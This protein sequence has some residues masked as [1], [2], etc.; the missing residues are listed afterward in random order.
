M[1]K[2][3]LFVAS[4]LTPIAKVGGLGDVIGSLPK[5]LEK[6]GLEI[7]IVIGKYGNIDE[8]KYPLKKLFD[9]Q[10]PWAESDEKVGI[11]S[12]RMPKSNVE[13]LL[14]DHELINTGGVYDS[15]TAFATTDHELKRFLLV[16]RSALASI[17]KLGWKPDAIHIHDWHTSFVP[18][19]LKSVYKADQFLKDIPVLLTIHNLANQGIVLGEIL[20][21]AGL[22]PED[23]P[24]LESDIQD[25]DINFFRQG[26][27]NATLLNTVSPTYAKEILT[28]KFGEGL[29]EILR[30][31]K[32]DLFGILN[33]IDAD[34][35]NSETD[36]DIYYNYSGKTFLKKY[37]NKLALQKELGLSIASKEKIPLLGIVSRLTDQKGG[38]LVDEIIDRLVELNCQLV[39]LGQGDPIHENYYKKAAKKYPKNISAN[40][41]F[42]ASLAQKIYAASDMFLMPSRFEPCGLGQMIAMRYGSVPIVR[43]TGG[44]VDTVR[45]GYTGFVFEEYSSAALY[46]IIKKSIICFN[47]RHEEFIKIAKNGMREDFSW[48]KSAKEYL[49]IYQKLTKNEKSNWN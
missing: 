9:L 43:K 39:V 27:E 26:I 23:L 20:K 48:G 34:R 30:R 1:M 22:K 41:K 31:R 16:S 6:L 24:S 15:P 45:D 38:E 10:V 13:V 49:K 14:M 32:K 25:G 35:F 5:A 11:Y 8:R 29:D 44:L 36:P 37:K 18:C 47:T 12:T 2:K 42:D 4:E 19:W 40:I 21:F 46:E 33:G 7:K 28:P 17:K 3:I